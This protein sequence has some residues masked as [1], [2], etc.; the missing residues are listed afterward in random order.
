ML[1]FQL[2]KL[3][4]LNRGDHPGNRVIVVFRR[5]IGI[6]TGCNNAGTMLDH[7]RPP[8]SA[9][10]GRAEIADKPFHLGHCR[11]FVDDDLVIPD[12][13]IHQF[14]HLGRHMLP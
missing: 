2:K 10:E 11:F 1:F 3:V 6:A 12:H 9:G 7:L 4:K 14:G 13:L 5:D 8:S